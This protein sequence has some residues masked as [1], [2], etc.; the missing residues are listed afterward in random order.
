[1]YVYNICK[2]SYQYIGKSMLKFTLA[3]TYC[4]LI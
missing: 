1:M 3:Y 4:E 2:N